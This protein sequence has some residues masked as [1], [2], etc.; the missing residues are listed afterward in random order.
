MAAAFRAQPRISRS[1]REGIGER[2]VALQL[3]EGR[4]TPQPP[5]YAPT[6]AT[7][8]S[9]QHKQKVLNPPKP[10]GAAITPKMLCPMLY[11]TQP[12]GHKTPVP[13]P[14]PALARLC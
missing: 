3:P 1:S 8:D 13:A 11:P 10:S 2:K 12:R 14:L 9:C 4:N 5:D 6:K 7:A